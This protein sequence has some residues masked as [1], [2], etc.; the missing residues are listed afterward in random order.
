MNIVSLG[1]KADPADVCAVLEM[2]GCVVIDR[3]L[4]DDV[5]ENVK[6][7]LDPLL[8]QCPVG[9]GTFGGHNT[10]RLSSLVRRTPATHPLIIH[11]LVL[12][13][14]AGVFSPR[15]DRFQLNVTQAIRIGPG[16]AAQ[17]L[18]RDDDLYPFRHDG[19]E[20]MV[21]C[22]WA[23]GPFTADN[24]A[25]RVVPGSH[26][27]PALRQA[28]PNEVLAAEMTPGSVLIYYGSTYH[29]GGANQT[30]LDRD[31]I[32]IGYALGWVRQME[33]QYL[34][35]PPEEARQLPEVLQRLIGYQAH[36]PNLGWYEC[37][38]PIALLRDDTR[39][40]A[41]AEDMFAPGHHE[42]LAQNMMMPVS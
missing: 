35:V 17:S 27:W 4:P 3:L 31:G 11:P 40:T 39:Q 12:S 19:F 22:M 34:A 36:R 15:C 8:S 7:E 5:I 33:N 30:S 18:H 26:R 29:G 23:L 37:R 1:A 13:V 2:D 32:I 9:E 10:R 28:S 14:M 41:G 21:N 24:G 6:T 42:K 20:V 38:D 16:E 25:T